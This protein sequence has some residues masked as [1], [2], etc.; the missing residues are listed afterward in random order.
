MEFEK[1][2]T[3]ALIPSSPAYIPL[4]QVRPNGNNTYCL[5]SFRQS[6]RLSSIRLRRPL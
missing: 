5:P 1:E 6:R 2:K 4:R 3:T